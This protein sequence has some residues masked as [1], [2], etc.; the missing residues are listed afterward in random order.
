[1][2]PLFLD[3]VITTAAF[4]VPTILQNPTAK[5]LMYLNSAFAYPYYRLY[6]T[7]KQNGSWWVKDPDTNRSYTHNVINMNCSHPG[8]CPEVEVGYWQFAAS[9]LQDAWVAACTNPAVDGCFIDGACSSPP[10]GAGNNVTAYE[11]GKVAAFN[12]IAAKAL[13]VVNNKYYYNPEPPYP[14]V[15]GEFIETFSGSDPKWLTILNK[16]SSGHL[17]Q[18]HTSNLCHNNTAD[19]IKDLAA[20][21][22]V[23]NEYSYFGCSSWEDQ[24][25]W[26]A[27]YDKPLG[28]PLGPAVYSTATGAWAR[29]FAHGTNVSVNYHTGVSTIDWGAW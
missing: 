14:G 27:E 26:V 20:F 23:A 28:P 16:S 12:A 10:F 9:G 24:P 15:Q 5:V 13:V 8:K 1:M 2:L 21:L 3:D 18:A 22:I 7:A 4:P 11:A 6:Q 25:T 19:G 29:S 17:V